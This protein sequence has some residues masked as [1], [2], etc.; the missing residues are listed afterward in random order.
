MAVGEDKDTKTLSGGTLTPMMEQYISLKEKA[1]KA[2]LFFRMGD[3]YELFHHDAIVASQA[4]NIALTSRQ[5]QAD[6]AIPMCGVPV[7]SA[8]GYINRLLQQGF[9]VAVAEQIEDPRLAEGLVKRDL[10]RIVTPGT[11][12]S[13]VTL[14]PKAHNFLASIAVTEAGAGFAYIDISTGIFA[15]TAWEEPSWPQAL[16]SEVE[17]LQPCEVLL[18]EPLPP[19]LGFLQRPHYPFPITFQPWA[20]PHFQRHRAYST[21]TRQ[22][23]VPTLEGF[24]C[25]DRPL[26]IAAAGALLAYVHQ[27]Q[28]NVLAHLHGLQLYSTSDFMRLDDT[29]RRHLELVQSTSAPGRAGSLLEVIDCTVT[30][31]GGRLLRQWITQ[32]LCRLEPILERQ[33]T[34]TAFVENPSRRLQVRLALEEM[35]DIERIVGRLGLRASAPRDVLALQQAIQHLPPLLEAIQSSTDV[36][37]SKLVQQW[38]ALSDIAELITAALLDDP[39]ATLREGQVI[40]PEYHPELQALR[41]DGTSG[42]AWLNLFEQQERERTGIASLRVGFNKIFGYFIEIRKAHLSQVPEDY[43]RKQTLTNAERF[44]TPALKEREVRMLRAEEEAIRLEQQLYQELCQQLLAHAPR[45]QRMASFLSQLDVLTS[46]AEVAVTLQ[47]N[48][49]NLDHSDTLLL[50]DSRHPVL[51]NLEQNERFVPNDVFLDRENQQ[52]ILLTGPNMAGK[53]TYMRQIALNVLLAQMGSYIPAKAAH[54]G[55]VDRI[56]TRIGAHDMLTKGQSTFMV[57]MTETASILHNM[58]SRSLI[59]LDEIGRGTSTYDGMSIAWGV[60]EY[61]HNHRNIRPRVLF[62]THYHELTALAASLSRVKN[63]TVAVQEVGENIIF[64]RK[65]LPGNADRSY[66]IQVARLAG[67]PVSV[68]KKAEQLLNRLEMTAQ[69]SSALLKKPGAMPRGY[70]GM[71]SEDQLHLFRTPVPSSEQ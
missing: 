64:L 6:E 11:T 68:I 9:C 25:A 26:A 69:R 21:L 34:V 30:A 1:G 23:G 51:E 17:R 10:V 40:R 3:F 66:G 38:D 24:G 44:V 2:L 39:A 59:L 71:L 58:S 63:Y 49:P 27:T 8:E 46:F 36:F 31:M 7:H 33:A 4:L 47:Y 52:I 42:K 62:A 18:P 14:A 55:L 12:I 20:A 29:T 54:I 67:L 15:V 13:D 22:F 48:L 37:L 65:V 5:K 43:I 19:S 28:Q 32:P 70:E 61:L 45:L 60:I 50:Q 56:F 57:E 41:E 53:S 35:V 16:S